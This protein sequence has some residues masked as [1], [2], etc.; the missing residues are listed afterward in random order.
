[1]FH[2]VVGIFSG[3]YHSEIR[4][5]LRLLEDV[6]AACLWQRFVIMH[7]LLQNPEQSSFSALSKLFDQSKR[8]L[9]EETGHK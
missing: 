4:K 8:T 9:L 5:L 7:V 3:L 2:Q 6:Q 1:M